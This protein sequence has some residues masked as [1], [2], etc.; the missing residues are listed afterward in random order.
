MAPLI[1]SIELISN[2]I[3]PFTLGIRLFAN[4]FADEKVLDTIAHL[5]P[6]ITYWGVPVLLMPLSLF[7][8][9]IQTFVFVLLSQLYI[10]EVSHPPHDRH[11]EH[12]E[13]GMEFVAPVLT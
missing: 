9:F 4:M 8:A 3:R 6:G 1:F 13:D 12:E 2:L 7:V 11:H 5:V 10:S